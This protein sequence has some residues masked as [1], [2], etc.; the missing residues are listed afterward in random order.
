MTTATL[1]VVTGMSGA[2]RSTALDALEDSGYYCVDNLP[3]GVVESVVETC[4]KGGIKNIAVGIDVR[5]R[6]FLDAAVSAVKAIRSAG[7]VK[8]SVVFFDA[9]DEVLMRRF[10]STRRPHPLNTFSDVPGETGPMALL[11]GVHK[12]REQLAGLRALATAVVDTSQFSVHE[13]RRTVVTRFNP[14]ARPSTRMRAR[15]VSFGFKYGPPL[16][17]DLVLDVRFIDNPYFI[18][19]L[20]PLTG[21]DAPVRDFVLGKADCIG[22]VDRAVELLAYALPRYEKEGKSYLTI[23]IGCT[24]GQHRSVAIAE[25]LAE[26]LRSRLQIG[27]EVAHRDVTRAEVLP[28]QVEPSQPALPAPG[29]DS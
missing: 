26:Q 4:L 29:S 2:G 16:E 1:L 24:G 3:P 12:E 17:A 8:V 6:G 13:L 9:S 19:A 11:T 22:F 21:L 7:K 18:D 10:S 20:R 25:H 5:A 14:D 15:I 27:L 23:A 28:P